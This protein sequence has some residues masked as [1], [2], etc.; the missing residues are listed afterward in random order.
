[1]E[2]AAETGEQEWN[3]WHNVKIVLPPAGAVWED[4]LRLLGVFDNRPFGK[5]MSFYDQAVMVRRA[6]E[7]KFMDPDNAGTLRKPVKQTMSAFQKWIAAVC[8][9]RSATARSNYASFVNRSEAVWKLLVVLMLG[10]VK[11]PAEGQWYNL[12]APTTLHAMGGLPDSMVIPRL[13]RLINRELTIAECNGEMQE[14]QSEARTKKHLLLCARQ[15]RPNVIDKSITD[16]G[17]VLE[18]YPTLNLVWPKYLGYFSTKVKPI[19]AGLAAMNND[20]LYQIE[21]TERLRSGSLLPT[22]QGVPPFLKQANHPL[23][24]LAYYRNSV[25]VLIN[26]T[27]ENAS[28][29]LHPHKYGT[30]LFF[31]SN[32]LACFIVEAARKNQPCLLHFSQGASTMKQ[33]RLIFSCRFHY[34]VGLAFVYILVC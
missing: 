13:V 26:S 15:L 17:D 32:Q 11:N 12:N 23:V 33:A 9:V 22:V 4:H 3:M 18:H 10:Q 20:V 14:L 34:E 2:L 31:L 28:K 29:Y 27:T 8:D 24:K 5:R 21:Y 7:K 6:Y 1:L 19:Q 30:S 25:F 16:F